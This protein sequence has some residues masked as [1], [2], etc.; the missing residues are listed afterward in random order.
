MPVA[1]CSSEWFFQPSKQLSSHSFRSLLTQ[2]KV[3]NSGPTAG[4]C[5]ICVNGRAPNVN[6]LWSKIGGLNARASNHDPQGDHGESRYINTGRCKS[7]A[8]KPYQ[9][10]HR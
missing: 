9:R 6:S 3:D 1:A 2:I 10:T 8:A 4:S 5:L 7:N